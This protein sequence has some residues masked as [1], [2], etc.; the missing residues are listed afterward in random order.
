MPVALRQPTLASAPSP[1]FCDGRKFAEVEQ[2]LLWTV[3]QQDLHCSSRDLLAKA[4]QHQIWPRVT[5]RQ[6]NRWR[7]KWQ[8]SRGKGRPP[9]AA[10]DGS[11]SSG[12]A[13]VCVTP[14]L[15]FVGVH[16]FACWLDQQ[17]AFEPVVAGLKEAISEHQRTHPGED[18]AL[19]HHRDATLRRRFQALVLAPLLGIERLSSFDTQEH[20]LETLIGGSYQYTT[21]SQFLGQLE[22]VEAGSSLRPILLPAQG[23][24]LVDVDGHMMAYWS[25]QPM[26]K[27][28]ITMRGRIMAGSQAVISH[29]ETGQAVFVAYYPPDLH[30]SQAIVAYCEQVAAAT[31]SDVFVIDR[32]VNAQALA[33]AFEQSGLGLLCMLDDN[34]HHGLESFEATE[35]ETLDDGTRLYQGPWKPVRKGDG[36]HFVI[37]EPRDGKTLVYWGTP[38]VE[39]GLEARQWPEVYRARTELQENAFKRMIEHGALDINAGRKTMVGP[40]RHQQRAEAKVWVS[41]EAAQSRVEKKSRALE[42]K[43]EQ[44]AESEAKGHG[45]RLEQRQRAAAKLEQELSEAE[46]HEA[47]WQ[48]QESGFKA[49]KTRADRDFRKQTIMTIRTLFLEN[50]LRAFMSV[51]LAVLPEKVSLEQVLK[52]LFERSGTR[53]E[54]D[55][56]VMYWVNTT[57]LSRSNRRLLGEIVEGLSAIGLVERGKTVHVCLKDLSP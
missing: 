22:R 40:D 14:R 10:A 5:L 53:I 34:E 4:A 6:I 27:G 11:M 25:R 42:A 16:L 45:K 41:L 43:R 32:A 48:E 49:P 18:F 44:V 29:D 54:R 56:E 20:P 28:K 30:L 3:L 8:L 52:L 1:S 7:A 23:G 17:E 51:L 38:K 15:S 9:R 50:L 2:A 21:L 19:L 31:G 26:H 24:K 57:G 37:V 13:V 46:Q 55:Q 35:V 36:R 12:N 47:R 33:Q 39:S